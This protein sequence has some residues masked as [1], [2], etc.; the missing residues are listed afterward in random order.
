MA[1]AQQSQKPSGSDHHL[2]FILYSPQRTGST[3]LACLLDCHPGVRCALEP[4]NPGYTGPA[5][6]LCQLLR[7]TQGIDAAIRSLWETFN[8]CKHIWHADG[9]PFR[10]DPTL[11]HRLLVSCSASIILLQRKNLLRRAISGQ[12]SAQIGI[13]VPSSKEDWRLIREHHFTAL[14]IGQLRADIAS[15]RAEHDR[16]CALA[17]ASGKPWIE[18]SY[19][20]FFADGLP[21]ERQLE[22]VQALFAF[23]GIDRVTDEARLAKMRRLFDPAYTGFQNAASYRKIPNI[24]EVERELGSVET[25]F[26]FEEAPADTGTGVQPMPS[27]CAK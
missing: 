11:N 13:W 3:T 14:D 2:P 10:D 22:A 6:Y 15:E 25:G 7:Q 23:L 20:D 8:G 9:W 18:V 5:A 17:A 4:F 27:G 19:E 24:A 12:I 1:A 26:V 21:M 16:V